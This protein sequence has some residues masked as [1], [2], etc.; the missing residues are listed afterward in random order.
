[1]Y[2]CVLE[3]DVRAE[4]APCTLH[5]APCTLHP[6][7]RKKS[8]LFFTGRR[9]A[10]PCTQEEELFLAA[11]LRSSSSTR[12]RARLHRVCTKSSG[13]CNRPTTN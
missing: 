1:M 8:R 4:A 12:R 6:A 2:A 5:P 7:H 3:D 13:E 11:D 10:S 9:A